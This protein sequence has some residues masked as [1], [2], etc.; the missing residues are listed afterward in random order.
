M[1]TFEVLVPRDPYESAASLADMLFGPRHYA[2]GGGPHLSWTGWAHGTI[3]WPLV[4]LAEEVNGYYGDV[5]A[6][7]RDRTLVNFC[8]FAVRPPRWNS[9]VERAIYGT[10][11]V[12]KVQGKQALSWRPRRQVCPVC[13][14]ESWNRT[15]SHAILW[16]HMAPLVEACWRHPVRLVPLQAIRSSPRH[17]SI[18]ARPIEST[19]ARN[20]VR[21]CSLGAAPKAQCAAYLVERLAAAGL[22]RADG[23]IRHSD[24]SRMLD[25]HLRDLL[26]T[27]PLS[28]QTEHCPGIG[29]WVIG[30]VHQ[31]E[32]QWIS[33]AY[34]A[35][36]MSLLEALTE[37]CT[38][39][40]E[41]DRVI[42]LGRHRHVTAT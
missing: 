20:V 12:P 29:T 26:S 24:F 6:L 23:N 19:Y 22:Q 41:Q 21:L 8:K 17:A 3:S 32:R 38:P 11:T 34:L 10:S 16:P 28:P 30:F 7:L 18:A 31:P 33:G 42:S 1:T 40:P 27:S 39:E 25:C 4:L 37:D 35:L 13:D 2:R 15:G 36:A 5:P 14:W 9:F